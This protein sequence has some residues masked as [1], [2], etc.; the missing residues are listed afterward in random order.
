MKSIDSLKA[1]SYKPYR[2]LFIGAVTSNIGT[3]VETVTIGIYMQSTTKNAIIVAGAMA[4]GYIPQALLGIFSGTIADKFPRRN[5]LVI[6]NILACIIALFLSLS[7]AKD[8]A[9]PTL[10]ISLIFMTGFLNA[11]SFPTWQGFFSDIVPPKYLPGALSLMFAQWNLGRIIGPAIAAIFVSTG[12]YTQALLLNA[13]SFLLVVVMLLLV[14]D[15]HY[16]EHARNADH[17]NSATLLL[18]G[19]KFILSKESGIRTP[20]LIYAVTIFWASPFISLLP[21]V[22]D[23]VFKYRNLG[24]SLFTSSQGIGAVLISVMI[25]TLHIKFGPT[26]TQQVFLF[27]LPFVLIFFGSS[28]NL[29]VATPFSFLF[30]VTYLGTLTSTTLSSQLV[31][32]NALKG[33]VSATFMATLGLLFPLASLIQGAFV[34]R[35]GARILFIVVG[36]S[37]FVVLAAIG[38]FRKNYSLPDHVGFASKIETNKYEE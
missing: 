11:I 37:L 30:G 12:H 13:F 1:L 9:T 15:D 20:Y 4:A 16:Q 21:N 18:D 28:P 24:T 2:R 25:T 23:E 32:P 36:A 5:T 33:R 10:V 6:T 38:A 29:F 26:R 3:W 7:V 8:F 17:K 31:A 14:K 35:F 19:W 22:A 34:N 27:T